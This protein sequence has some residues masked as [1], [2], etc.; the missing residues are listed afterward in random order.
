MGVQVAEESIAAFVALILAVVLIGVV[1]FARRRGH[2]RSRGALIGLAGVVFLLIAF[3]MTGGF[4][5]FRF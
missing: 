5:P 3:G 2:I 1:L 4:L